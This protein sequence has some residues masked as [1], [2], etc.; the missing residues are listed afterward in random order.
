MRQMIGGLMI[1]ALLIVLIIALIIQ[2]V[3]QFKHG[4][5][6]LGSCVGSVIYVFIAIGL[7]TSAKK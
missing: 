5:Y 3:V 1:C 4:D 2:I 6:Q 7:L